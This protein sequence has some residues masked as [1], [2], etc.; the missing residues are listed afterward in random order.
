[1]NQHLPTNQL[2]NEFEPTHA[3]AS[4]RE[5]INYLLG[6]LSPEREQQIEELFFGDDNLF[7]RLVALKEKLI[8]DY[9]QENLPSG[10]RAL[11]E[12]NFLSSPAHREQVEFARKLM[13]SLSSYRQTKP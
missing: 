7:D 12:Q 5:M 2:D 1:M 3:Q 11:F 13:T 9:L 4:E 8:D 6:N 10:D